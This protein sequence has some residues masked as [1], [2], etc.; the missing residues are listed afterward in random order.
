MAPKPL[1]A[2]VLVGRPNVGKSTLFNRI[3]GRRR[4][5]VA[6]TAGTTR[7]SIQQ[8]TDWRNVPFRLADTAGMFG[9]SEDPLQKLVV[10]HGR[11][12]FATADL[13]IF[14]VDGRDGLVPA[15]LEIARAIHASGRPVI[16][17][18]NKMDDRR[19]R[20]GALDFYELGFEPVMEISAEH[21][22]GIGDLLDEVI[23]RLPSAG[24]SQE[25]GGKSE[26]EH[27]ETPEPRIAIAGRPNVGKSSLVNRILREER[28][29]VSEVAGTTRD[30][31]DVGFRWHQRQFRIVDTAG[32]RKP[33]RVARAGQVEAISVLSA[34]RAVADADVL[35][36]V[37]D[38]T[39]GAA[40]QDGAIAGEAERAGRSVIIAVNKW[41]L[42]KG[43]G[44]EFAAKFDDKL[45]FNLKFLDY[46]PIVHVSALTGERT[47]KLIEVVDL[48]LRERNR[49]I[50]TPEL[51]KFF[52]G[53]VES[54]PIPS[55]G[56]TAIRILYAAQVGVAPP[57]FALFTNVATELHF[58]YE[59]FLKNRLREKF[60][61][62]GTPIR[63]QVRRRKR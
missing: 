52:K 36:L 42:V 55:P 57:T 22:T 12:A 47:P 27:E 38:A 46:A 23:A 24:K 35:V 31:V 14:V 43:E 63:L 11:R 13:F 51:N 15:D 61:F 2:V 45:R 16:V 50:P 49:R 32:I 3:S 41:D 9:Q 20:A 60:G 8:P 18:I 58:S 44:Q 5:I 4:A 59:R 34:R 1:P 25:E 19:A 37:I 10:E 6:P 54:H 29:L 40:D 62:S 33:G 26:E 21:G 39:L 48:V 17:A 56:R 7:D 53:V 30:A 28:V